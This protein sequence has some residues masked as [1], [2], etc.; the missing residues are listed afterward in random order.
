MLQ[1]QKSLDEMLQPFRSL[2]E[3]HMC[4]DPFMK[5]YLEALERLLCRMKH[6]LLS[7]SISTPHESRA[8][9]FSASMDNS[10]LPTT[11][12]PEECPFCDTTVSK[13]IAKLKEEGLQCH[14][15]SARL[16]QL[17]GHAFRE[18]TNRHETQL[19]HR[20]DAL[21]RLMQLVCEKAQGIL[22]VHGRSAVVTENMC[23]R[24]NSA[25]LNAADYH[26]SSKDNNKG[27][28][29]RAYTY[30]RALYI[31]GTRDYSS[32]TGLNAIEHLLPSNINHQDHYGQTLLHVACR[33]SWTQAAEYLLRKGADPSVKTAPHEHLPIH[34]AAATGSVTICKL[35]VA[36]IDKFSINAIDC[37][38]FNA[39]DHA[40]KNE[41]TD[42]LILLV[43]HGATPS[44]K[45]LAQEPG[46][47]EHLNFT[48]GS[49]TAWSFWGTHHWYSREILPSIHLDDVRRLTNGSGT[50]FYSS[51]FHPF[52]IRLQF[53]RLPLH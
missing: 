39:L 44:R 42:V 48:P 53:S 40:I 14:E 7:V 17:Y 1:R 49:S 25:L 15:L 30:K 37:Y 11:I 3:F 18:C 21:G 47:Y 24:S 31:I 35:L 28:L 32:N 5:F 6:D 12:D 19:P 2:V 20:I 8:A 36:H 22:S 52:P 45:L 10:T 41:Q 34:F 51:V 38:G 16:H 27:C 43:E 46:V 50:L 9:L 4:Y 23:L 29:L 26:C 13:R 33:K